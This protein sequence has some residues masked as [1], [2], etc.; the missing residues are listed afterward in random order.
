MSS[1]RLELSIYRDCLTDAIFQEH[2][3]T[4]TPFLCTIHVPNISPSLDQLVVLDCVVDI[5]CEDV[6]SV[7]GFRGDSKNREKVDMKLSSFVQGFRALIDGTTD[8]WTLSTGLNLFLCQASIYS[9][10]VE[11]F[12]PMIPD[13]DKLFTVPDYL[14][15]SEKFKLLSVNLWLVNFICF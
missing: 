1:R 5:S 6:G 11:A 7:V 8:H 12:P 15:R 3:E 4:F 10:D 14:L 2:R 9:S 13:L